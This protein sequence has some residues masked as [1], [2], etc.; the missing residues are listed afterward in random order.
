MKFLGI[1]VIAFSLSVFAKNKSSDFTEVTSSDAETMP[2][3]P[4]EDV[5]TALKDNEEILSGTVRVIRRIEMTEVFFKDLNGSYIIP[6][7]PQY[8]SIYKALEESQKKGG[9]VS[10]KANTKTRRIL[11]LEDSKPKSTP[12]ADPAGNSSKSGTH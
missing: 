6:S 11:T 8:S 4:K 9:A 3:Q 7:G 1:L 2:D 10:F 12:A 5:K